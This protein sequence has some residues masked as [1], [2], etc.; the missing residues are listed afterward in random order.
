M[1]SPMAWL[2]NLR[3]GVE[4]VTYQN[5]AINICEYGFIMGL[6]CKHVKCCNKHFINIT[7]HAVALADLAGTA[8][9]AVRSIG[10]PFGSR[11]GKEGLAFRPMSGTGKGSKWVDS[12][13]TDLQLQLEHIRSDGK[14]VT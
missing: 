6:S 5:H 9:G 11:P 4:T 3:Y 8:V 7:V 2:R 14:S 12:F 13:R 10:T 1:K